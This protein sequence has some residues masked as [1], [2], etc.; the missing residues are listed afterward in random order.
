MRPELKR[1]EQDK[2]RLDLTKEQV[3]EINSRE[4]QHRVE[5]KRHVLTSSHKSVF[6][7]VIIKMKH[8]S[9]RQQCNKL[10][11]GEL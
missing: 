7:S 8:F 9:I 10:K 3:M 2:T 4:D 5:K 1:I 11:N 6:C